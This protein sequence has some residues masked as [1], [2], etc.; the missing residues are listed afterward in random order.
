MRLLLHLRLNPINSSKDT[1]A[2]RVIDLKAVS[3]Q[4]WNI[5]K[6]L[7]FKFNA[8]K[9]IKFTKSCIIIYGPIVIKVITSQDQK[10]EYIIV[11]ETF[12]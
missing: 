11:T 2:T 5:L 12:K 3:Y 1:V 10:S 9:P 4:Y 7:R 6:Q 8:N